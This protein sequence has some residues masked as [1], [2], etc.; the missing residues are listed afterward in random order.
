LRNV[1]LVLGVM[2]P[3][4]LMASGCMGS[5]PGEDAI[6]Q[7]TAFEPSEQTVQIGSPATASVTVKNAGTESHTFFIGYSVRDAD[8]EWYDAPPRSVELGPDEESPDQ[9]LTTEPLE[10]PGYYDSRVSVWS[11][12]PGYDS[13]AER[14]TD[15]EESSTFR[16]SSS[17]DDF[18]APELDAGRWEAPARDLGLGEL[19]PGDTGTEDGS[20]RLTLPANTLD[21]GEIESTD[22]YGPGFYAARI[23]VPDAPSSITGFFLYEPPDLEREIDIEI[24]NDP[25]GKILF[26]TYADGEQTHTETLDLPFDPTEEFHEYAFFYDEESVIFYVDDEPMQEFDGGLPN[27]R[28][29]LHVNSWFPDWLSGEEYGSDHYVFVDWIEW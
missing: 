27:E 4:A 22:R 16:A 18:D 3:L 11:E 1:V 29:K 7:I 17:R 15:S 19:A 5:N 20:L 2:L 14:L 9:E 13:S 8:G 21:G 10:T 23:K 28:M 6:V 24:Y 25:S 26:T 12:E